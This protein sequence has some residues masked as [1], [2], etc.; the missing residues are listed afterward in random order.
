MPRRAAHGEAIAWVRAVAEGDTDECRF[1]P[2]LAAAGQT[3]RPVMGHGGKAV[4][5]VTHVVLEM[6]G[7][8]VPE[9]QQVNRTCDESF[10]CNPKHLYAGTQQENIRDAVR[11]GRMAGLPDATVAEIAQLSTRM[12]FKA[13]ARE[14][15]ITYYA[16]RYH[17]RR[18]KKAVAGNA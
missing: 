6:V 12:G 4:R 13:I 10:C 15:G 8:P 1:W 14:M 9:G 17:G 18:A 5:P 3:P 11:R 2:F 16:A 7:R